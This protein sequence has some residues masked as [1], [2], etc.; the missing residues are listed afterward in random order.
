MRARDAGGRFRLHHHNDTV[1][2]KSGERIGES[3]GQPT[4]K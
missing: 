2:G 3:Y 1:Y 4:G